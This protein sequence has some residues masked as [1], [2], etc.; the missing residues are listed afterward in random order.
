MRGRLAVGG[1]SECLEASSAGPGCLSFS[2]PAVRRR[3][4]AELT[5]YTVLI[6]L[7]KI[8]LYY[9]N[10]KKSFV[11]ILIFIISHV[12]IKSGICLTF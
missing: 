6:F 1:V 9:I 5:S 12:R 10:L 3:P 8:K 11:K 4:K 7:S 2:F